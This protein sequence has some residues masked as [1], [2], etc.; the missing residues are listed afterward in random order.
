LRARSKRPEAWPRNS[1][2]SPLM[3]A[4]PWGT[5]AYTILVYLT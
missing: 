5:G 3:T 4:S 1:I 2:P